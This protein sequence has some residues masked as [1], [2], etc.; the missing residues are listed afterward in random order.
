MDCVVVSGK[1]TDDTLVKVAPLLEMAGDWI[2]FLGVATDDEMEK[3]RRHE[4]SGRPLGSE[5]FVERLEADLARVL[6]IG[7]PG[8]K[9]KVK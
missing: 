4:R 1:H 3:I 5:S 9:G 7:K 8:P 2:L 6:K